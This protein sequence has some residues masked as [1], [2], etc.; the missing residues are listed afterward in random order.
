MRELEALNGELQDALSGRE[1][2]VADRELAEE[3]AEAANNRM[4]VLEEEVQKMR[5]AYSEREAAHAQQ[6][7]HQEMQVSQAR[8][9][10]DLAVKRARDVAAAEAGLMQQAMSQ[11]AELQAAVCETRGEIDELR[12]E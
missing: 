5:T 2:L 6:L 1:V 11:L 12:S 4:R 7:A 10:T 9:E 8:R 3:A